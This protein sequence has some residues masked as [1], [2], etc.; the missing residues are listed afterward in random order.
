MS[1][2]SLD[3]K[4]YKKLIED[5]IK[6]IEEYVPKNHIL[7]EHIIMVLKWSVDKQYPPEIWDKTI[8]DVCNGDGQVYDVD[9]E[10]DEIGYSS[11]CP[12]C[13]GNGILPPKEN[14]PNDIVRNDIDILCI[15]PEIISDIEH[16]SE[17]SRRK[18][19]CGK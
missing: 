11:A 5:D 3:K 6:L 15:D 8:C 12:K 2:V 16:Y 17:S 7:K 18:W 13:N 10:E 19:C 9:K 14:L 1:D 4:A